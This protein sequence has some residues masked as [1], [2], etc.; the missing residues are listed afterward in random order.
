MDPGTWL[1]SETEPMG[2][3]LWRLWFTR[4]RAF[5]ESILKGLHGRCA[6][7]NITLWEALTFFF[8]LIK[9]MKWLGHVACF[10]ATQMPSCLEIYNPLGSHNSTMVTS[11]TVLTK[12]PLKRR[13]GNK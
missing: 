3:G 1:L 11:C 13:K 9:K 6:H 5:S 2:W 12:S 4:P 10:I 8:F 7:Q